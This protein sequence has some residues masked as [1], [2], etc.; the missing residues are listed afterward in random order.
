[1]ALTAGLLARLVR[2]Q[3]IPVMVAPVILGASVAWHATGDFSA[4]LFLL[5]L[6]GAVLLHL[7]ANAIDDAYDFL[8]G[9]DKIAEE[10]FPKDSPG[11]KPVAR[12]MLDARQ[13]FVVSYVLYA[14]SVL[15]GV[16]LSVEVGW[17]ALGIAVPGILLSYFYVAPPLKLDYRGLGLGELSIL[18][19]FGPIPALGV[20]YVLTR[21]IAALP[22]VVALPAGLLTTGVLVSHDAIFYDVYQKAGKRTLTVVMGRAGSTRLFTVLCATAYLIVAALVATGNAPVYCWLVIIALP[23][24]SKLADLQGKE[25]SP[26]EYGSRTMLAFVHSVLFTLLLSIGFLL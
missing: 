10:L 6:T 8:N 23:L 15:I 21:H 11:W 16:V 24:F 12:K 9:T 18:F 20:Y 26:P 3:F 25:R 22:V 5:S 17:W 2:L 4:A 13:A 1:M 7:A 14:L 19:C